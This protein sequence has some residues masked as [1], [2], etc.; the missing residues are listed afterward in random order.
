MKTSVTS[1]RKNLRA[2]KRMLDEAVPSSLPN[3]VTS[4]QPREKTS[5]TAVRK[6]LSFHTINKRLICIFIRNENSGIAYFWRFTHNKDTY[7]F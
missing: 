3:T 6:N 2:K 7:F 5:V 4:V 1:V